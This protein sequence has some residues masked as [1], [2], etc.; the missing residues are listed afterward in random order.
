MALYVNS[1]GLEQ[2][3]QGNNS[4]ILLASSFLR[5]AALDWFLELLRDN[6][7]A[8]VRVS[9]PREAVLLQNSRDEFDIIGA[10]NGAGYVGL[11]EVPFVIPV[12]S[13]FSSFIEGFRK[14]FGD[15]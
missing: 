2:P 11:A 15:E 10:D 13:S 7:R 9:T 8:Y 4:K 6:I 14:A 1:Q 12:L 5:G 3:H